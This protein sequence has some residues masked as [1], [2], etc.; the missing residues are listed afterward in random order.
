MSVADHTGARRHGMTYIH[1]TIGDAGVADQARVVPCRCRVQPTLIRACAC[2]P[3]GRVT[4]DVGAIRRCIRGRFACLCRKRT[5]IRTGGSR[6]MAGKCRRS[7]RYNNA[8]MTLSAG[9]RAGNIINASQV[10]I[11][12][13]DL[14]IAGCGGPTG[15]PARARR[16]C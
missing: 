4:I 15:G 6:H 14:C 1:T 3:V 5:P 9:Y 10:C 8:R 7:A 13:A 12:G 2:R 11:M 16:S